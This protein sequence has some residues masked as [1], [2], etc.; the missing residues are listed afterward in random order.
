[1]YIE[2][3]NDW[4]MQYS[5]DHQFAAYHRRAEEPSEPGLQLQPAGASATWDRRSDIIIS[6]QLKCIL[7]FID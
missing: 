4:L 1:M 5:P 6:E 2:S 3:I 7:L